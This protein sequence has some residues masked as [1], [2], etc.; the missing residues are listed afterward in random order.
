MLTE[1]TVL[2]TIRA[3]S[4][5]AEA[6]C[7]DAFFE[8]ERRQVFTKDLLI[9]GQHFSLGY[10]HPGDLGWKAA[11]VN[12]SDIAAMGAV[13]EF[14]LL[15]LGLP[16]NTSQD[17]V[18]AF[19]ESLLSLCQSVSCQLVGGD[20]V[21]ATVLTISA[22]VIGYLP[23]QHALGVRTAACPGDIILTTGFSGLSAL[24]LDV[25]AH[26]AV[27]TK[28]ENYPISVAKHLRPVPRLTEAAQ[29]ALELKL[30]GL[31]QF[32]MMDTSDG[33]ADAALKIATASQVSIELVTEQLPMHSELQQYYSRQTA[34][35][36]VLYG[37]EDFEL[38]V[39][40]PPAVV[41][42]L[43]PTCLA[44]FT[45]IGTVKAGAGEVF[46][47][48]GVQSA[49]GNTTR[50]QL[51]PQQTYQHFQPESEQIHRKERP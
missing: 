18:S 2:T 38:F 14:I 31:E 25:L 42:Q 24:G 7:D 9:E 40:L 28:R 12:L 11:A 16:S 51:D 50:V 30:L 47:N 29:L 13:P 4:P 15:G 23:L 22:T 6:L 26:P 45:V 17:F 10:F 43:S 36:K 20:T 3:L 32:C 19:Y 8:P 37:G 46:L 49:S 5:S 34:L 33:L 48:Y 44:Y 35:E 1:E 39:T 27:Q 41:A 21:G